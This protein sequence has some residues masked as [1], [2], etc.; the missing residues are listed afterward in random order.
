MVTR[1]ELREAIELHVEY[2]IKRNKVDQLLA[3]PEV[4]CEE[5]QPS[6]FVPSRGDEPYLS[7]PRDPGIAEA[8]TQI[9]DAAKLIEDFAW[10][11]VERNRK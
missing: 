1:K 8:C 3:E 2:L 4:I 5:G 10:E 7:Q 9:L 11:T 6:D